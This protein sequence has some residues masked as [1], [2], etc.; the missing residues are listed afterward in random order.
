M[1]TNKKFWVIAIFSLLLP[2]ITTAATTNVGYVENNAQAY[3]SSVQGCEDIVVGVSIVKQ[4][5]VKI[6]TPPELPQAF[7]F[8]SF[9][10]ICD[11]GSSYSFADFTTI[12]NSAFDQKG[13]EQA[14][15]NLNTNIA[16]HDIAIHLNWDGM[17]KVEKNKNK[18]HI[19]NDGIIIHDSD[20]IESRSSNINGSFMINGINYATGTQTGGLSSITA[21][22]V[23]IE[24]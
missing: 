7:I 1:N 14:F 17:G 6:D 23:I 21:H 4:E 16:G 9:N 22:T 12:D 11:I 2:F 19:R 24:K 5:K 13:L 20:V 10:N 15:L 3:F 8:G 18:I